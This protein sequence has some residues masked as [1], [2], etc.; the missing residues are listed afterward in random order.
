MTKNKEKMSTNI[1]YPKNDCPVVIML[2][3]KED[4]SYIGRYIESERMFTLSLNDD[5]S[6][7]IR[8][9]DVARWW[10]LNE[11]PII[12]REV[13]EPIINKNNK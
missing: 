10:Y 7:F 1:I 6:D 8:R 4:T 5:S 13:I 11:H 3:G 12:F 9:K 2:K